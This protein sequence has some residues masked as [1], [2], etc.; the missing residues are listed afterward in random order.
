MWIAVRE[1]P[2]DTEGKTRHGLCKMDEWGI[3]WWFSV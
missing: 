1:A 2:K 3:P